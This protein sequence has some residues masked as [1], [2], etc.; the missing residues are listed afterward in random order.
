MLSQYFL[1]GPPMQKFEVLVSTGKW[2]WC[3][4]QLRDRVQISMSK[5]GKSLTPRPLKGNSK[6]IERVIVLFNRNL[7]TRCHKT[8]L[9]AFVSWIAGMALCMATYGGTWSLTCRMS[10]AY[11]IGAPIGA[12]LISREKHYDPLR[13]D[14]G[15]RPPR[16]PLVNDFLF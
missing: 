2:K 11:S 6:N 9:R 12:G 13:F 5:K 8:S 15:S 1:Q 16:L 7:P 4:S 14:E 10:C 3:I